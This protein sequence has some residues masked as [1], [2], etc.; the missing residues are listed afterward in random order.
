MEPIIKPIDRELIISELTS[1]KYIRNTRKGENELYEVS[2]QDSPNIMKEIGRLRELSFR[3]AGGGTGKSVDIDEFDVDNVNPYRQ[4]IVWDPKN[5]EILGGYRYILCRGINPEKMATKELFKFSDKFINEILP[6]TIEL[7]RSF[8]QPNY[9]GTN[10]NRKGL[11]ALDNLWDGLGAIMLR[12]DTYN[13]FFGKVTMYT[14]Y[15]YQARNTLLYFLNKY[16]KDEDVLVRPIH[17]LEYD[18]YNS[19][20]EHIFE[21]LEYHDAYKVLSKEIRNLGENIPPLINSY[22]NLTPTMKVF[23]TSINSGFGGVEETGIL[24]KMSDV[25]PEKIER[26]LTPIK[27][28]FDA[29]A[30]RFRPKWW[31]KPL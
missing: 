21:G 4:L 3:M 22:M 24:L 20:Y 15:N 19:H 7:G 31:R 28:L 13:Y 8:I 30:L 2:A 9:Q 25:Y 17:S 26:H 23:G 16:F 1:D 18:E 6:Q 11:Y 5:Q 10:I 27:N 29:V 12:Y 14:S